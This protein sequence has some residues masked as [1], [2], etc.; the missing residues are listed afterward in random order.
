MEAQ[1]TLA[2]RTAGLSGEVINPKDVTWASRYLA[3]KYHLEAQR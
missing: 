3:M 2:L 1:Q